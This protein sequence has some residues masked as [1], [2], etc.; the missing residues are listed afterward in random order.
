MIKR[1]AT[2]LLLATSVLIIGS[3]L[4]ALAYEY[5]AYANESETLN[6]AFRSSLLAC[7]GI[8][9]AFG[10]WPRLFT[11]LLCSLLA[12]IIYLTLNAAWLRFLLLNRFELHDQYSFASWMMIYIWVVG[13]LSMLGATFAASGGRLVFVLARRLRRTQ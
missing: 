5:V 13:P 10:L 11:A 1:Q 3:I 4:S 2:I 12:A 7:L 6:P 8:G 9:F